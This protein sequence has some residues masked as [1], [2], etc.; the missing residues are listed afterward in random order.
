MTY[1]LTAA[2]AAEVTQMAE[3]TG[4]PVEQLTEGL[5]SMKR[6]QDAMATGDLSKLTENDLATLW[7]EAKVANDRNKMF[8]VKTEVQN[9]GRVIVRK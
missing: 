6:Q 7:G 1:T 3:V 4:L 9:R 5:I 2:E 8:L